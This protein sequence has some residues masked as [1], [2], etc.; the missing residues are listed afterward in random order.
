MI[1]YVTNPKQHCLLPVFPFEQQPS[2]VFHALADMFIFA[3]VP[4]QCLQRERG[5]AKTPS[6]ISPFSSPRREGVGDFSSCQREGGRGRDMKWRPVYK[7][8]PSL[9]LRMFC[10]VFYTCPGM[11]LQRPTWRSGRGGGTGPSQ[12]LRPRQYKK[13]KRNRE[14]QTTHT[15]Q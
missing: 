7:K 2:L 15:H 9:S 13:E 14:Y 1:A 4:N 3:S 10:F 5:A 6:A 12:H 11:R 8:Y